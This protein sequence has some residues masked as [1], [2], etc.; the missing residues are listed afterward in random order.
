MTNSIIWNQTTEDYL[1]WIR[2]HFKGSLFVPNTQHY[3]ELLP[4]LNDP[5]IYLKD[6]G[7]GEIDRLVLLACER[8]KQKK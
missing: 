8:A 2:T 5:Y 4:R 1:K 7:T 6:T 3:Q